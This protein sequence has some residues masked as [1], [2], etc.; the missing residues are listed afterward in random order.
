L[1]GAV[2]VVISPVEAVAT[3]PLRQRILRP[4][5]T[6][7]EI[8]FPGD[9]DPLS[10]HFAAFDGDEIVG[11]ASVVPAAP[12]WGPQPGWRLRGM[13]SVPAHRRQGV[14]RALV[15]AVVAHVERNGGGTLWCNARLTAV[16]FYLACGWETRGDEW[17]EPHIGP[18]IAMVRTG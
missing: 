13:A 17:E 8:A 14:G 10:A 11:V 12:P 7:E 2:P 16:G 5:Q 6:I 15:D 1:S 9:A 4:H 3:Y 18:H